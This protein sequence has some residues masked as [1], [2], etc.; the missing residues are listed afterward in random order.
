MPL[1]MGLLPSLPGNLTS[2]TPGPNLVLDPERQLLPPAGPLLPVDSRLPPTWREMLGLT[3]PVNGRKLSEVFLL[4][5]NVPHNPNRIPKSQGSKDPHSINRE[6]VQ[7]D[8]QAGAEPELEAKVLGP[9]PTR[10]HNS[11]ASLWL[12]LKPTDR[13]ITL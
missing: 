3:E 6:A 4:G 5:P 9:S 12:R 8:R 2:D 13:P 1:G 7:G 10:V 11:A